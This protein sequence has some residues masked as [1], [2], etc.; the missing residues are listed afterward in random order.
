[1]GR[2]IIPIVAAGNNPN[3][4]HGIQDIHRVELVFVAD[5]GSATEDKPSSA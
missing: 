4:A 5:V 1:M 3:E 2:Q